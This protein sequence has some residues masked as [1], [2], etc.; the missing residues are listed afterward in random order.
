[1]DEI[2]FQTLVSTPTGVGASTGKHTEEAFNE[3]FAKVKTYL[4]ALLAVAS[5]TVTSEQMTQIKVDTSVTPHAIYYSMDPVDTPASEVTW[6]DLDNVSFADLQ[7]NPTDNIA[8]ANI[9]NA[10]AA[11]SDFNAL[12]ANVTA[13]G[14][15]VSG[16]TDSIA[17]NTRDI[18]TNTQSIS[19]IRSDMVHLVHSPTADGTLYLRYNTTHTRIEYSLDNSQWFN[20]ASGAVD[21][22]DISGNP[23]SN[24]N[25]VSYVTNSIQQAIQG[26]TGDFVSTQDFNLHVNNKNNPHEVTKEQI[27]LGNVDNTA[28]LDKP[29]PTAMQE[30]IDA[31]WHRYPECQAL[32]NEDYLDLFNTKVSGQAVE[33][34]IDV[35]GESLVIQDG[36]I[37][38]C[39]HS[40]VVVGSVTI[41]DDYSTVFVVDENN[42]IVDENDNVVGTFTYSTG[43]ITSTGL[44]V[45]SG[46][47]NYSY[48]VDHVSAGGIIALGHSSINPGSIV[49][50]DGANVYTDDTNG[51]LVINSTTVGTVN[52]VTGIITS[53][54]LTTTSSAVVDYSYVA[55]GGPKD[56]LYF[57]SS[58][59]NGTQETIN[60]HST[61]YA[62]KGYVDG[63]VG[64]INTVLDSLT[65]D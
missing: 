1:M 25:L 65:S 39:S 6:Y 7:G 28:D 15:T 29:I 11:L 22:S 36:G 13:L 47:I 3:N 19:T 30:E 43:I 53:T 4:E 31:L 54:T 33:A 18:S 51:N 56:A 35:V 52:Y 48:S 57:T 63:I 37:F 32:G 64:N 14:T 50:T 12:S 23:T 2:I 26:V 21:F 55:G 58:T 59:F 10:K 34:K 20:I 44:E 27:G 46:S 60:P 61:E 16:H 41:T 8:L 5:I 42:N 38:T 24:N 62:T 45:S 17:D 9:L 40:P 49:L